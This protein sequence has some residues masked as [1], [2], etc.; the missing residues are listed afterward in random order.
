MRMP[1][2]NDLAHAP[3]WE[4]YI[5]AQTVSASRGQ[6]PRHALAV[7]VE[8]HGVK[9]KL[10]FQL[11]QVTDEDKTDME[12][13]LSELEALVGQDVEVDSAYEIRKERQVSPDGR[14]N[15][16]WVFLARIDETPSE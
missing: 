16:W 8:I 5:V 10:L 2:P 4:I 15:L 7:G 11:S 6:I 14:D 3:L 13:I 9:I 12:D 1:A